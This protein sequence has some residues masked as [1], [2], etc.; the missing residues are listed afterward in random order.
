MGR[1]IFGG[2]L[3]G[4]IAFVW[5][6][7]SWMVLPWHEWT[8]QSFSNEEFVSWVIKENVKKDGVYII[9]HKGS[10]KTALTPS[11]LKDKVDPDKSKTKEGPFI[12]AQIKRKGIDYTSPKQ[13]IISFLTQFV[14]ASL[15]S[16]LLL[17]AA[18][19]SYMGRLLFVTTMGLII[20]VL[21]SIPNWNWFGGGN[22]FLLISVA[23]LV[24]TWFLAG[25]LMAAV[26]KQKPERDLMM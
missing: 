25:L 16:F 4:I 9:P 15:I 3:G 10:S 23:D 2:I 24:I 21:G 1:I 11:E 8:L 17:K 20:G 6:F 18:E 26:V 12:Y 22:L 14:G 7:V 13:Y 5:S 19:S